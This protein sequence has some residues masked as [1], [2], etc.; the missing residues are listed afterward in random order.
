MEFL[1]V[2]GVEDKLQDN[3]LET[4]EKFR[5]AGIQV[6]M[7]TGDKIETAKCIA[8]ATGMNRKT[9]SVHEIRGDM[10][11]RL[12]EFNLKE[13]IEAYEKKNKQKTMLMVDGTCLTI[14][15][16]D[17]NNDLKEKFFRVA[18]QAKSVCICRCSPTQKALVARYIKFYTKKNIACVGDGGNDVAMI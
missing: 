15:L 14:I 10:G 9:E 12:T 4:I 8:I 17:K 11:D 2:T 3:V 13:S 16:A 7:L 6:W 1:A 18:G 5:D